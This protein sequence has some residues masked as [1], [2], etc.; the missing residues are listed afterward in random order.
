MNI[1]NE[2]NTLKKEAKEL[3][4]NL[5]SINSAPIDEFK[6]RM[7]ER[8]IEC[9]ISASILEVANLQHQAY[10]SVKNEKDESRN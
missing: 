2:I 6:V 10:E 1:D 7:V 5:I 8:I 9:I 4:V 3:L